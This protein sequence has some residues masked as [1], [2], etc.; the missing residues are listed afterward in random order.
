MYVCIKKGRRHAYIPPPHSLTL[1]H[2]HTHSH[3]KIKQI[4]QYASRFLWWYHLNYAPKGDTR[5]PRYEIMFRSS[6]LARKCFHLFRSL[7]ELEKLQA[8]SKDTKT[9]DWR[10][11][12]LMVRAAAMTVYWFYDNTCFFINIKLSSFDQRV[13]LTRDGAAWSL[14][15]AISMWLALYDLGEAGKEKARLEEKVAGLLVLK[16][17]GGGGKPPLM[18]TPKSSSSSSIEG[19]VVASSAST[20]VA[21]TTASSGSNNTHTNTHTSTTPPPSNGLN[22]N[23]INGNGTHTASL[24]AARQSSQPQGGDTIS[25]SDIEDAL[26][27]VSR[28]NMKRFDLFGDFLR[29]GCDFLVACN[30]TGFDLP[31]RLFG[32]KLNDGVIGIAG[33]ISAISAVYKAYPTTTP[34]AA[35]YYR[36]QKRAALTASVALR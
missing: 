16:A 15:N 19:D 8:L 34:A 5:T 23:G 13:A 35:A 4:I 28:I 10:R 17:R 7:E 11:K 27:D 36:K 12:A 21:T 2:P 26:E 33:L 29:A 3:N 9:P 20:L 1:T 31:L 6:Q 25:D 22:G 14:A 18:S 32:T 24:A 30:S